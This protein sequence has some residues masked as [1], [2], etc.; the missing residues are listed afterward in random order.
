MQ[1]AGLEVMGGFIVG[2]DGDRSDIFERQFDFIQ[3]AGIVTAMVGL[4]TALPG[5]HLH[6]R[7]AREGRLIAEL[8]YGRCAAGHAS[9]DGGSTGGS[10]PT[11][12]FATLSSSGS[13]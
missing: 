1:A 2:F 4:L 7:L 5:T 9:G 6:Q 11:S 8:S 12:R 10:S 3:R 13:R